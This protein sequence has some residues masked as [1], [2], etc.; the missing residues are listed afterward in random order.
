MLT[1]SQ[2]LFLCACIPFRNSLTMLAFAF[3]RAL[4]WW[5][6]GL[7]LIPAVGFFVIFAFGLRKTGMET[8]GKPIGW[9]YLRPVHGLFWLG[10]ACTVLFLRDIMGGAWI[11][12]ALDTM[13][14]LAAFVAHYYQTP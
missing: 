9:N 12:L 13:L 3:R 6:G 1:T 5:V 14:G 10:F 4:P 7:A 8:G 11:W 2:K